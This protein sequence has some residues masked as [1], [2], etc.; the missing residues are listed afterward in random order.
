MLV[1]RQS[2]EMSFTLGILHFNWKK[3][4]RRGHGHLEEGKSMAGL[5]KRRGDQVNDAGLE[6]LTCTLGIKALHLKK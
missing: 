3:I 2:R 5:T 1:Q 4:H 6:L